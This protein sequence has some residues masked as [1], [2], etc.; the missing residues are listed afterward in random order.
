[1]VGLLPVGERGS[2]LR[3]RFPTTHRMCYGCYLTYEGSPESLEPVMPWVAD[4]ILD[5]TEFYVDFP[6]GGPL[7]VVLDDW[8]LEDEF[9]Y[10]PSYPWVEMTDGQAARAERIVA[11]L[12][13]LTLPQ[14]AQVLKEAFG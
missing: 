13:R 3:V 4:L 14:R 1:M 6:T 7:H 12:K 5:I 9:L 8:N 10:V 11:G 2:S